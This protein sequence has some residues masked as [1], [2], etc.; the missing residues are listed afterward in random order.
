M[1][2]KA[3]LSARGSLGGLANAEVQVVQANIARFAN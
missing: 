2:N 3:W 1:N